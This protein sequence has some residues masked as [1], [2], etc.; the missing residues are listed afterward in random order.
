MNP[1][2]EHTSVFLFLC[3]DWNRED[4]AEPI[5]CEAYLS[6]L[7]GLIRQCSSHGPADQPLRLLPLPDSWHL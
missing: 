6:W 3:R 4:V 1:A 5:A 7:W 2:R